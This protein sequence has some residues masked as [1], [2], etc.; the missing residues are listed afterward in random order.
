MKPFAFALIA[1]AAPALAAPPPG[2]KLVWSD[3]FD[4][5]TAPDPAK[6]SYDTEANKLR[7]W[8]GEAQ[9]YSANRRENARIENG[10]LVIEVRHEDLRQMP[11]Y[12]GQHYT[13]AR[14]ITRGKGEWTYGFFEI[15][16]KLP[17]NR[18][19]W[20]AIWLLG[21]SWPKGGEIDIMEQLGF[22]P[23]TI[24]GTLHSPYT[25]TEHVTQHG[26]TKVPT[27]CLAFHDYQA[28]WTPAGITI[29]VDGRSYA[30]IDR[31]A[32][33]TPYNW[34]FDTPEFLILNFAMGGGWAGQKGI[35][36]A[37]LPARMEV[38]YVRVYQ[39]K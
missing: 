2:Y 18:G 22:D 13:S 25:V 12:A 32:S 10:H 11:D 9:Y 31:P 21:P 1:A 33:A 27:S 17:Y 7:W 39:K 30:H 15:H 16:A 20:P 23:T 29:A 24:Y 5:G 3:E 37:A 6:W 19:G 8:H 14:L 35:D 36:D 26:I 38:D 34:P 28:E 4:R